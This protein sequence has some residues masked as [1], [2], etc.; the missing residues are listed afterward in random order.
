MGGPNGTNKSLVT[1]AVI[2]ALPGATFRVQT[3]DGRVIL[4]HVSGKVRIHHIRILVGDRV[5]VE[6]SPYDTTRGRIIRRL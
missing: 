2:E 5:T 3:E 6:L 1:G 4:A